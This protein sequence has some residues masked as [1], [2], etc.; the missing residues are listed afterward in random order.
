MTSGGL[1][2]SPSQVYFFG[3]NV[4]EANAGL[5][6]RIDLLVMCVELLVPKFTVTLQKR[7]VK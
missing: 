5:V 3:I 7:E 2:L 1:T 4:F 6:I